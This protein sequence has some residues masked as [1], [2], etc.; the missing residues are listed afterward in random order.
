MSQRGRPKK[1]RPRDLVV[2]F[3]LTADAYHTLQ[4]HALRRGQTPGEWA[5]TLLEHYLQHAGSAEQRT[6]RTHQ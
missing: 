6:A 3:R 4:G 1:D 5:R 2:S